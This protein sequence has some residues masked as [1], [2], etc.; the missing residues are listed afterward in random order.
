MLLATLHEGGVCHI[1]FGM[2]VMLGSNNNKKT[3]ATGKQ[4]ENI[5]TKPM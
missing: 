1:H 3:T 5:N 4:P 2:S